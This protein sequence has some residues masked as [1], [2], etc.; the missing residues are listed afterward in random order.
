MAWIWRWGLEWTFNLTC[1]YSEEFPEANVF[2]W[3]TS[4]PG[5]HCI[6]ESGLVS[7]RNV[8]YLAAQSL[9]A[10]RR[11]CCWPCSTSSLGMSWALTLQSISEKH[12]TPWGC[13]KFTLG[14]SPPLLHTEKP[15][16][17]IDAKGSSAWSQFWVL[18]KQ[19]SP[20][21]SCP[22]TSLALLSRGLHFNV[23]FRH[24]CFFYH[25]L[26]CY[27]FAFFPV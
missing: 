3:V 19:E 13:R 18:R 25:L 21:C 11:M 6:F 10:S 23:F 26:H 5:F 27:I 14:Q 2:C 15:K 22:N 24:Q 20:S 4:V 1:C 12:W 7:M 17:E 8:K 16:C 9:A